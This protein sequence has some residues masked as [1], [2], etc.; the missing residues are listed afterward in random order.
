MAKT[1]TIPTSPLLDRFDALDVLLDRLS[2]MEARTIDAWLRPHV[3]QGHEVEITQR[4][5]EIAK[6]V[7]CITCNVGGRVTIIKDGNTYRVD[8]QEVTTRE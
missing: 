6:R 2:E 1:F 7:Q 3:A 5:D 8:E 4:V